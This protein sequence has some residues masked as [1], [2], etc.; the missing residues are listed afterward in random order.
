MS[1]TKPVK[2]PASVTAGERLQRSRAV[3]NAIANQHLEGLEPDAQVIAEL[4]L[5]AQGKCE[6]EDVL[7][8]YKSRVARRDI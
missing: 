6:L 4:E 8:D 2:K 3:A 5:Y 7:N 1:L